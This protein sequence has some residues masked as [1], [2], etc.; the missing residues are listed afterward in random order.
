M[1]RR[2]RTVCALLLTVAAVLL[3]TLHPVEATFQMQLQ[4]GSDTR[5]IND[6]G[7][8]DLTGGTPG[9]ITFAGTLGDFVVNVTLGSS[10][11]LLG[12]AT[13]PMLNITS[14]NATSVAGGTLTLMLSDTDFGPI[15]PPALFSTD[16]NGTLIPGSL[17]AQTYVANGLEDFTTATLVGS[18]GPLTGAAGGS[19]THVAPVGTPF[20][21]NLKLTLV[22]AGAGATT[23]D[24]TARATSVPE[25]SATLCLGLALFGLGGYAGWQRS[26]RPL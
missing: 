21:M 15:G 18:V 2:Q 13:T 4:S 20:S 8:G 26:K 22:H 19:N 11:P 7:L 25:P 3:G 17:S 1:H 9:L 16:L 24:A 5:T 23:F 6:N 12:S 10:K 14:F